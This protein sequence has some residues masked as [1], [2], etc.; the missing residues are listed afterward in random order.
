MKQHHG[1]AGDP[2]SSTEPETLSFDKITSMK[3]YT[4]EEIERAIDAVEAGLSIKQASIQ[5]GIPRSTLRGHVYGAQS[6][7]RAWEP[8]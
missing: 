1:T 5:W 2:T 8:T 7:E 3:E 4:E 6:R